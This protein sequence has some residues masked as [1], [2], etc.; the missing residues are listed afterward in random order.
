M[1]LVEERVDSIL[2]VAFAAGSRSV[3]QLTIFLIPFEILN[4]SRLQIVIFSFEML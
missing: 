1:N 4:S 3:L 2:I